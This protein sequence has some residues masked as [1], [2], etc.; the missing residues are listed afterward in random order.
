[1][2]AAVVVARDRGARRRRFGSRRRAPIVAK[3]PSSSRWRAFAPFGKCD[4]AVPTAGNA[5][6]RRG[7]GRTSE[8]GGAHGGE[9]LLRDALHLSL[10]RSERRRG[11]VGAVCE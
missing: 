5:H 9:A 4:A 11:R 6:L 1:V 10:V 3:N 8:D 7:E 2:A